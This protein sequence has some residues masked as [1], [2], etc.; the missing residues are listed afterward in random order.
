[1]LQFDSK[2]V[3]KEIGFG[4]LRDKIANRG[5]TIGGNWE[6]YKGSFDSVLWKEAGE[7]IYLRVPF[8]VTSGSLIMKMLKFV[9]KSHL[10]LSM[11]RILV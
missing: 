1:M 5:F 10:S 11:L 3:G 7:T 6:Y 9:F 4:Y 8:I 2:I